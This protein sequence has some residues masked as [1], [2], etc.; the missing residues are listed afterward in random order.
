VKVIPIL[1]I[2][3]TD[4]VMGS[5]LALVKTTCY[6]RFI[7]LLFSFICKQCLAQRCV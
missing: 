6:C 1:S 5:I 2:V 3:I 7:K 4:L